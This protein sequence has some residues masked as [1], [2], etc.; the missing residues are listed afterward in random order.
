M[1]FKSKNHYCEGNMVQFYLT[2]RQDPYQVPPLRAGVDLGVVAIKRHSAF[3][4]APA[5]QE[6]HHQT[7]Q[8]HI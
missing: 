3:P 2:D 1:L 7:V 6:P 4:K 5:L 8:S